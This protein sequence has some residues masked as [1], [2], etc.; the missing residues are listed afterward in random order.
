ELL[1]V[2]RFG[3]SSAYGDF[4]SAYRYRLLRAR[5]DDLARDTPRPVPFRNYPEKSAYRGRIRKLIKLAPMATGFISDMRILLP[6]FGRLVRRAQR[7]VRARSSRHALGR[8][9]QR[10]GGY[11]A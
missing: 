6:R 4:S 1:I 8:I 9:D 2:Q 11:P 10:L 3:F 5:Q 7:F